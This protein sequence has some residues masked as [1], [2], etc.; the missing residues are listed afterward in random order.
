M[1]RDRQKTV[2]IV[3][4]GCCEDE[5]VYDYINNIKPEL[6]IAVDSGMD[7]FLRT[8]TKPDKVMGDFDSISDEAWGYLGLDRTENFKPETGCDTGDCGRIDSNGLALDSRYIRYNINGVDVISYDVDRKLYTDT[9]TA[10]RRAITEGAE[11]IHILAGTG[12]RLDQFFGILQSMAIAL[13]NRVECVL[14]DRTNRIRLIDGDFSIKKAG[15]FGHYVSLVP[16]SGE[17][18]GIELKGFKYDVSDFSLSPVGAG[19]ISNEIAEEE[20]FISFEGGLL[21]VIES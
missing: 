4:G 9:E 16:F 8:K 13:K 1:I 10:I 14:V 12:G 5:F 2:C 6:T 20:A 21:I 3:T 7:F 11:S 17:I 19:G 18:K 15:Q